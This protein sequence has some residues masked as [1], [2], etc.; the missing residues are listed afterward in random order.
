MST[1]TDWKLLACYPAD[2][3]SKKEKE[4]FEVWL[5]SDPENQGLIK[6][7]NTIWNTP[8]VHHK[9]SDINKLWEDTKRSL[10]TSFEV[11]E[12]DSKDS[13][14]PDPRPIQIPFLVPFWG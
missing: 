1:S 11:L 8:E 7:L 14:E 6:I 13:F 12:T 10:G 3:C 4:K 9:R 2:E 5:S